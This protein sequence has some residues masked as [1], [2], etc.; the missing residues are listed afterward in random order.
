[1]ATEVCFC[2]KLLFYSSNTVVLR[3]VTCVYYV[4]KY[5]NNVSATENCFLQ[6]LEAAYVTQS[7]VL[8]V[9]W[10]LPMVDCSGGRY[11]KCIAKYLFFKI[12]SASSSRRI[13]GK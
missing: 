5:S 12:P 2:M 11:L 9:I 1:M 10:T 3:Q 8:I 7:I 6:A 13:S 4:C